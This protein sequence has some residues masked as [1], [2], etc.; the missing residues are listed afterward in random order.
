[1]YCI[2]D[3]AACSTLFFQ[4]QNT[5]NWDAGSNIANECY[6]HLS[7]PFITALQ[8]MEGVWQSVNCNIIKCHIAVKVLGMIQYLFSQQ[9]E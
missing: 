4:P 2:A 8:I 5:A 1:M 7:G 9:T 3:V 6:A